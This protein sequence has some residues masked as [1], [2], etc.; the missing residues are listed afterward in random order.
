M[1]AILASFDPLI[2]ERRRFWAA[3]YAGR[4]TFF[5]LRLPTTA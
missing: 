1:E 4:Y 2:H 3:K 5:D